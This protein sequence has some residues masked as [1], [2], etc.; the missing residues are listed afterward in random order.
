MQADFVCF[1]CRVTLLQPGTVMGDKNK[2]TAY[3]NFVK[4]DALPLLSAGSGSGGLLKE[5]Q[6]GLG[7]KD[8]KSHLVLISPA[9]SR[10]TFHRTSLLKACPAWFEVRGL[11]LC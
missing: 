6:S 3:N 2:S 10:D 7:W 8:L 9:K 4:S 1:S 11:G 5:S